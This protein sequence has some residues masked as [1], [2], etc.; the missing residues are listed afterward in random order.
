MKRQLM[1]RSAFIL[2]LLMFAAVTNTF[3]QDQIATLLHGNDLTVYYGAD[4]FIEAYTIAETGD[5]IT[6]SGGT[7]NGCD[8]DKAVTIHGAGYVYDELMMMEPTKFEGIIHFSGGSETEHIIVEGVYFARAVLYDNLSFAEFNKCLFN[9]GFSSTGNSSSA[10]SL[11]FINSRIKSSFKCDRVTNI[12]IINSTISSLYYF[13]SQLTEKNI[14]AYNSVI[15]S[16]RINA[17]SDNNAAKYCDFTNC[18]LSIAD[19]DCIPNNTCTLNN[20]IC[21]TNGHGSLLQ[22]ALNNNC[23]EVETESEVFISDW[24]S[25]YQYNPY[26]LLDEIANS[27]VGTDGTQV[28]IYGGMYPWTDRPNHM[29]M[30]RCTVGSRTTDDGHLSV[31]IEV[32]TEQ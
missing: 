3:A 7:F 4:A 28:G 1:K 23:L 11:R 6:L 8:I 5:I 12:M 27:I 17:N 26:I 9:F 31:D 24:E 14:I 2:A 16:H 19:S 30:R 21:I 20:C 10:N 32:V 18:I 22:Y 13:E 25:Q 29:I 15:S